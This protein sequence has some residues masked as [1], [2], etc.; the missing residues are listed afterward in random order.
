MYCGN[1]GNQLDEKAQV[2]AKCGKKIENVTLN[3]TTN[4]IMY[5]ERNN[6][7]TNKV[8]SIVNYAVWIVFTLNIL[9]IAID[10]AE[11]ISS[12]VKTYRRSAESYEL[13]YY[14]FLLLVLAVGIVCM[15]AGKKNKS[16][17]NSWSF[18]GIVVLLCTILFMKVAYIRL[19]NSF[20]DS[21]DNMMLY[22]ISGI[23]VNNIWKI[24][25]IGIFVSTLIFAVRVFKKQK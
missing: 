23:Y 16:G 17:L 21:V 12:Y 9:I 7:F 4:I 10:K 14:G 1:C 22:L 8:V 19:E 25:Y 2:C 24:S 13:F 5:D 3:E 15:I 11:S 18:A 6:S 20:M